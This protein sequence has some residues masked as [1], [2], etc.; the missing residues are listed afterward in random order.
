MEKYDSTN[1]T[2]EHINRVIKYVNLITSI[3]AQ[4]AIW[5][6]HSKLSDPELTIFNEVTPR[7]KGLTYGSPEYKE[8]LDQ[9]SEALKHH[10]QDNSHHPEHYKHGIR[11]MTLIDIVEM[12]CDWCAATERHADGDIFR[13]IEHNTSRF[14]LGEVLSDIFTNTARDYN[15][16][17]R[18][19]VSRT[20][21][22]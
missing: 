13:S 16:G 15:I 22:L 1:D 8:Q 3:L 10:Y 20:D 19:C 11:E 9:M 17:R 6:D 12:F 7:L 4:R 18:N 5:H 21:K 14:Q 2:K